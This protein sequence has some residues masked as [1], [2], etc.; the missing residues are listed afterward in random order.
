MVFKKNRQ[1]K[2]YNTKNIPSNS[3]S[4][5]NEKKETTK[6]LRHQL[7]EE[8]KRLNELKR[9]EVSREKAKAKHRAI[10]ESIARIRRE[11]SLLTSLTTNRISPD[12]VH[13]IRHGSKES[14]GGSYRIIPGFVG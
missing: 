13:E 8:R 12:R 9:K 1:G 7:F 3:E 10:R 14:G 11:Q 5:V 6:D 4:V 2:T